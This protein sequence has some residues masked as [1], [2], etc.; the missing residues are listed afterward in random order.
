PGGMGAKPPPNPLKSPNTRFYSV[1][2][3]GARK[4]PG[5]TTPTLM[6]RDEVDVSRATATTFQLVS[7]KTYQNS[8]DTYRVFFR[9]RGSNTGPSS[10]FFKWFLWDYTIDDWVYIQGGPD[11]AAGTSMSYTFHRYDI[12]PKFVS[13]TTPPKMSA[14]VAYHKEG[15]DPSQ[16]PWV[17]T[18]W[19]VEKRHGPNPITAR[20]GTKDMTDATLA[21]QDGLAAFNYM[22]DEKEALWVPVAFG[23]GRMPGTYYLQTAWFDDVNVAW[24]ENVDLQDPPMAECGIHKPLLSYL[25]GSPIRVKSILTGAQVLTDID[26]ITPVYADNPS[27]N[28]TVWSRELP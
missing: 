16:D 13:G 17:A 22:W 4:Q 9:C 3:D 23:A 27:R 10:R 7:G 15:D 1:R 5:E 2:A 11:I 21:N 25:S 28:G 6:I 14:K 12:D 8:F 26:D 20:T 24:I 18:E 19:D